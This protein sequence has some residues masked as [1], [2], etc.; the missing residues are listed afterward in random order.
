MLLSIMS[1]FRI[2]RNLPPFPF[3]M[4]IFL[5]DAAIS[6]GH[7]FSFCFG[8]SQMMSAMMNL[9]VKGGSLTL[10]ITSLN[11]F[12]FS[13]NPSL[14]KTLYLSVPSD[15]KSFDIHQLE[16]SAALTNFGT[17]MLILLSEDVSLG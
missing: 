14:Q 1:Y 8:F 3:A 9:L 12:N 7:S 16:S 2:S 6:F 5:C 17:M 15:K 4:S 13:M 11:F 10:C